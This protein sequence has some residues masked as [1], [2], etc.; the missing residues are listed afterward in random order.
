MIFY[1][2]INLETQLKEKAKDFEKM[3]EEMN[4]WLSKVKNI[5][6]EVDTVQESLQEAVSKLEETEKRATNVSANYVVTIANSFINNVTN[7]KVYIKL[8]NANASGQNCTLCR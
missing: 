6:T 3:E 7:K 4:D 5:Q 2:A 8:K 1:R